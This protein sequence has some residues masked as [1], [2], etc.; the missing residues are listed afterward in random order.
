MRRIRA[1]RP[2]D[3]FV[4]RHPLLTLAGVIFAVG[5][6]YDV[7]L[8]V[9]AVRTG[10]YNYSQVIPFGSVFVGTTHQFPLL[11]QALV[12]LVMIPAGVLLY[13]EDTG[14]T[15]AEKLAQR[16]R[17]FARKPTLGMFVVMF[18]IVNVAYFGY[19]LGHTIIKWT[20]T[21]SCAARLWPY[22]EAKA[23]DPQGFY[24]EYDQSGPFSA[25]KW[26]TWMTG[27]PGGRPDVSAP[28]GGGRCSETTR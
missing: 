9:L 4:S 8:E 10:T 21:A 28:A 24:E 14:G 11:S 19:G 5:F 18:A 26:S 22:S 2:V 6:A 23:Y 25:G 20:R 7:V 17:I 16:V 27:Q 12:T 3:S 15:V 1:R 13:R